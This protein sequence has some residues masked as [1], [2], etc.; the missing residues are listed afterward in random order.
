V[1]VDFS[2]IPTSLEHPGVWSFIDPE[3]PS[4]PQLIVPG[5]NGL[6]LRAD[7][8]V[9][10]ITYL[11]TWDGL[12]DTV[13]T[14]QT[15][16]A[17]G[18][19]FQID[20]T[21]VATET[22]KALLTSI[23]G[24]FP[25]PVQVYSIDHTD[26][27]PSR[28]LEI[29]GADGNR[30]QVFSVSNTPG[31]LPWNVIYNGRLYATW[32]P[33]IASAL[34]RIFNGHQ[35]QPAA[36]FYPGSDPNGL[37]LTGNGLPSALSQGMTGLLPISGRFNY[38]LDPKTNTIEGNISH[39]S[40]IVEFSSKVTGVVSRLARAQL[41]LNG[42]PIPCAITHDT[43]HDPFE[44]VIYGRSTRD[45][46][47]FSC[48]L[49]Q[50]D[51]ALKR[52]PI[53]LT[54]ATDTGEQIIT[55]GE[56]LGLLADYAERVMLPLPDDLRLV[57]SAQP[58]IRDLM[59]DHIVQFGDFIGNLQITQTVP[60]DTVQ[61]QV[62]FYGQLDFES[63]TVPYRLS[64]PVTIEHG[65]VTRWGL[66]RADLNE[67]L[68][69]VM[70]SPLVQ[71]VLQLNS[72]PP[73][74]LWFA[75]LQLSSPELPYN[76]NGFAPDFT[77]KL[78][79]CSPFFDATEF[80]SRTQPLRL[81]GFGQSDNP[82]N[83][84]FVLDGQQVLAVGL[85]LSPYDSR[86]DLLPILTPREFQIAGRMPFGSVAM[87]ASWYGFPEKAN[88]QVGWDPS[89]VSAGDIQAYEDKITSG[90]AAFNPI[91]NGYNFSNTVAIPMPDGTLSINACA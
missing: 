12:G 80:P 74:D 73:L 56:L 43:S 22:V 50:L 26:D 91:E 3:D 90:S 18:G 15:V 8:P 45:L 59:Q 87:R 19:Q 83:S 28:S 6:Q 21:N 58:D 11:Y 63:K 76:E 46:W 23:Q 69:D 66:T 32:D 35:G 70:R 48:P 54:F 41:T 47:R 7:W 49:G 84:E 78:P 42:S 39:I 77:F 65:Q 68:Q 55:R 60:F 75:K 2:L 4:L 71:R 57:L 37:P 25:Y 38:S 30:V 72:P 1:P 89:V 20:N 16:R 33:G 62:D 44:F 86:P 53:A 14:Y 9:T 27:Y 10:T 82:L 34:D 36:S 79:Q 85:W 24:L 67:F 51:P 31:A 29:V 61:A 52:L 13:V 40:S 88:I 81:F 64:T 5:A 17:N